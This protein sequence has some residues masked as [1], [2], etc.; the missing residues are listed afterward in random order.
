MGNSKYWEWAGAPL[1]IWCCFGGSVI[2]QF[3][4]VWTSRGSPRS[5]KTAI[6]VMTGTV[7]RASLLAPRKVP[8]GVI[9]LLPQ[10]QDTAPR[11]T[12]PVLGTRVV[13][14]K[15]MHLSGKCMRL[16]SLSHHNKNLEWWTLK[17]LGGSQLLEDRPCY[18]S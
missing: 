3:H 6:H 5:G 18:S 10:T 12:G 8:G 9:H 13:P 14:F 15:G 1:N 11:V 17:P 4:C 7:S 2:N 16:G